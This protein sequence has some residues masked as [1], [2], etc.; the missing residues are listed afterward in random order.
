MADTIA[1]ITDLILERPTCLPC[2]ATRAGTSEIRVETLLGHVAPVVRVVREF[3]RR[4]RA[5]GRSGIVVSVIRVDGDLGSWVQT[6][7]A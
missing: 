3:G 6:V 7:V 4:C 1:L 5:C 2:I